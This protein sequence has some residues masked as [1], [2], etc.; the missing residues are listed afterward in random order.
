MPPSV[1]YAVQLCKLVRNNVCVCVPDSRCVGGTC[2]P[3]KPGAGYMSPAKPRAGY[4]SPAKPRAGY[5][6]PHTASHRLF[7]FV[8]FSCTRVL[9]V[10]K[11]AMHGHE[12][13]DKALKASKNKQS[14]R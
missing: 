7:V 13:K 14:R 4:M 1:L 8:R 10:R 5:M 6:S 2:P 11:E 9:S 3:A 12:K